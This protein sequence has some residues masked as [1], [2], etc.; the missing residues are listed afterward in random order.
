[1]STTLSISTAAGH[2]TR[3]VQEERCQWQ[4]G[5]VVKEPTPIEVPQD[6]K[7]TIVKDKKEV[8][9]NDAAQ[10]AGAFDMLLRAV[11]RTSL[12]WWINLR[13]KSTFIDVYARHEGG[14]QSSLSTN[15]G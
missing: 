6:L 4:M 5:V 9:A 11:V 1:M 12:S 10:K 14:G 13:S 8:A 15:V 3:C 2:S 7:H